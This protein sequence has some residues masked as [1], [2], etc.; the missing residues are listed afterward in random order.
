MK[1]ALQKSIVFILALAFLNPMYA[2]VPTLGYAMKFKNEQRTTTSLV[3]KPAA[4]A[5]TVLMADADTKCRRF[6]TMRNIGIG[7]IC[8]GP[9]AFVTGI[10]LVV[11]GYSDAYKNGGGYH[12]VGIVGGG[13]VLMTFGILMTGAGIPLTIIGS[14]KSKQWCNQSTGELKMN[15]KGNGIGF[16]YRF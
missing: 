9:A 6:K 13:A 8:A 10:A 2:E 16:A 15:V 14:K 3:M 12:T 11:V 4:T 5:A 7:L 1:K